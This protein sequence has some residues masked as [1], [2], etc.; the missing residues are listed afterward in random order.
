MGR[1]SS[2]EYLIVYNA[3]SF[4]IAAMG[5]A[6]IFFTVGRS[7]VGPRYRP[8]LLVSSL[9]VAIAC[10]HYFRIFG[11]WEGAYR[12][13]GDG[14]QLTG[15]P[16]N[17]AYRYVDWLLTVPLLLVELVSVM[18]L[19][20]K[21]S[22]GM[23]ARLVAAAVAMILLGY[24]GEVSHGNMT[25]RTVWGLASTVP[26]LYI[27]YV[28]WAELGKLLATETP[29]VQGHVRNIRLLLLATWGFY[30]ITYLLPLL[31]V[32]GATATVGIQLGY[33]IADVLAKAGYG[34]MIYVIAR[35]KSEADGTLP[36]LA[37]A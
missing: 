22:G 23:L 5:A 33:A 18:Q 17:D 20:R 24:P 21:R 1:I 19:D 4:T 37:A 2:S 26:F 28:L 15:T 9:V 36:D 32:S 11:S 30:P 10:Y 16:F 6:F 34:L 3:L 14:Y 31:G 7:Q 27:L 12:L 13:D 8:A 35:A 29:T 25:A